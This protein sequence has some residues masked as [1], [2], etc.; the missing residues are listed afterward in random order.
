MLA[1]APADPADLVVRNKAGV[2]PDPVFV[3]PPTDA[4]RERHQ[5][6][7]VHEHH[8]LAEGLAMDDEHFERDEESGCDTQ[9]EREAV[10]R[11]RRT[12]PDEQRAS[13]SALKAHELEHQPRIRDEKSEAERQ[14]RSRDKV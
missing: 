14:Q 10:I 4:P 6:A 5:I 1:F 7:E 3:K 13:F 11:W 9:P 8:R 12:G 2:G